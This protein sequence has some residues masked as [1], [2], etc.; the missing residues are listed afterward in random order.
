MALPAAAENILGIKIPDA[1]GPEMED[2]DERL[3]RMRGSPAVSLRSPR[4][5]PFGRDRSANASP[6]DMPLQTA[7]DS[8]RSSPRGFECDT[9]ETHG[10]PSQDLLLP[11]GVWPPASTHA[12]FWIGVSGCVFNGWVRQRSPACAAASAAGAWNAAHCLSRHHPLAQTQD[13]AAETMAARMRGRERRYR[14]QATRVLRGCASAI[15]AD[16]SGLL[17]RQG[18]SVAGRGDAGTDVKECMRLT[19][20]AAAEH[21]VAAEADG[22]SPSDPWKRLIQWWSLTADK[23]RRL[24]A[25]RDADAAQNGSGSDTQHNGSGSENSSDSEDS[26]ESSSRSSSDS[27]SEA[28]EQEV[29]NGSLTHH[30]D[31]AATTPRRSS[32]P[33]RAASP[34]RAQVLGTRALRCMWRECIGAAKL[35]SPVPSSSGVGNSLLRHAV[36]RLAVGGMRCKAKL[37]L[38]ARGRPHCKVSQTDDDAAVARQWSVVCAAHSAAQS[39]ILL[40]LPNHYALV[41]ALRQWTVSGATKPTRQVLTA[42]RGQRPQDWIDFE[43]LRG[44]LLR[45]RGHVV[46]QITA[47][48]SSSPQPHVPELPHAHSGRVVRRKS[49]KVAACKRSS[50]AGGASVTWRS[51]SPRRGMTPRS[52]K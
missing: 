2:V 28:G 6:S 39:V 19:R 38:S 17:R 11:G 46:L 26:V 48:H 20:V 7:G 30:S 45:W 35:S 8:L 42:R 43:E 9:E 51:P 5:S 14:R 13:S 25:L 47:A 12:H 21:A 37:L 40:H 1:G 22:G 24:L 41:Y 34:S 23:A 3:P 52:Q 33:V 49:T 15:V 50:S 10:E 31:A 29:S 16:V 27:E 18:K 44:Y 4:G 36:K 32:T